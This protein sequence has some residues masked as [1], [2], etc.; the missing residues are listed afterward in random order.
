MKRKLL[1]LLAIAIA[2][3]GTINAQ[4]S[5]AVKTQE[6]IKAA[7]KGDAKAQNDF[8]EMLY[9]QL[10]DKASLTADAVSKVQKLANEGQAWAQD[11]MGE[12]CYS[13]LAGFTKDEAKAQEWFQK[14]ANQ[15]YAWGITTCGTVCRNNKDYDKALE[16]YRKAADMGHVEALTGLGQLYQGSAVSMLCL[17]FMYFSGD[18]VEKNIEE[19]KKWLLKAGEAG[20]S[21]GFSSL[22]DLYY[23]SEDYSK[24]MEYSRK[25]ADMGN[26]EA[27]CQIGLLYDSGKGVAKNID[28]ANQWYLKAGEAGFSYGYTNL[29]DNY[30]SA[31]NY[32]KAI[33]YFHKAVEMGNEDAIR[34]EANFIKTIADDYYSA[35]DNAKAMEYYLKAA[36]KGNGGAMHLIAKIYF[37][38]LGVSKDINAAK[39]WLQ[40]AGE[41]GASSAYKD[42][43][44]IAQNENDYTK[45][46]EYYL[47]AADMGNGEAMCRIGLLY[48]SGKGVT[49]NIDTANQWYLKAGEA[50]LSYGYYNL[51]NNYNSAEEYTK[52][53]EYYLKAADMGNGE[54]MCQIGLLYNLGKGV[55]KNIDTANQWYLKAGEAGDSDGYYCLA[56]NC[57]SLSQAIEYYRKAADMGNAKAMIEIGMSYEYGRGV[58]K[59]VDTAN[60]W[61]LKAGEAGDPEGYMIVAEYYRKQKKEYTKAIELYEKAFDLGR[62]SC[63]YEIA[64]LYLSHKKDCVFNYSYAELKDLLKEKSLKE[65]EIEK[66]NCV[67]I[68]KVLYWFYKSDNEEKDDILKYMWANGDFDLNW[69]RLCQ[70][71]GYDIIYMIKLQ[72]AFEMNKT[73]ADM[74]IPD[75]LGNGYIINYMQAL[76][77]V[78][79]EHGKA[80]DAKG[81]PCKDMAKAIEYYRK[82]AKNGNEKAQN[83]LKEKGLSW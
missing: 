41:A 32:D 48:D 38:G 61:Y 27:M 57:R 31:K 18:G 78:A 25:A 82:A 66:C 68:E 71:D 8:C 30:K 50:G 40:K 63:S 49:K 69:A 9:Y 52:A 5:I 26:G 6:T 44:V 75:N 67:N 43:A 17:G 15:G 33:E 22:V 62:K 53:M 21:Y 28:T 64:K 14:A 70:E 12:V 35:E 51:A 19:S 58:T 47:K 1:L 60:Q 37:L 74:T 23:M 83:K 20:L 11:I 13:G 45:A 10:F 81:K 42:L 73:I 65:N 76:T 7:I 3:F 46:M 16:Y 4:S 77:A 56:E 34:D 2:C 54:A 24:A 80:F 29:A 79:Y 36:D 72:D 55:A 39:Q 59:N